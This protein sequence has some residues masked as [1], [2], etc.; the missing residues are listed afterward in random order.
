MNETQR[1]NPYEV[2][3]EWQWYHNE[4][5]FEGQGVPS[6]TVPAQ[7]SNWVEEIEALLTDNG[8]DNF[9]GKMTF[10]SY[11]AKKEDTSR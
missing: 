2:D 8:N 1:I 11:M 7:T 3:K 9:R 5:L 4:T 6:S 10:S